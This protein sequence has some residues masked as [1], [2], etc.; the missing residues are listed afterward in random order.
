MTQNDRHDNGRVMLVEDDASTSLFLSKMLEAESYVVDAFTRAEDALESFQLH[1]PDIVLMD[2]NLEGLDGLEATSRIHQLSQGKVP[3]L[4]I[5]GQSDAESIERGFA[6]GAVDFVPKPV[7]WTL[8]KHRINLTLQRIR[9]EK[10]KQLL[11]ARFHAVF[12]HSPMGILLMNLDGSIVDANRMACEICKI[13]RQHFI[14]MRCGDIIHEVSHDHVL[15]GIDNLIEGYETRF[16]E[17]VFMVVGDGREFFANISIS[18]TYDETHK[19]NH[20]VM[21]FDDITQKKHDESRLRLAARVFENASEGIMVTDS[22]GCILDVNE[23]FTRLTEYSRDEVVGNN[24][25]LLQSGHQDQD[26]YEAMWL[27]LESSGTWTGE[28]W[29]RRKSGEVYPELL[30]INAVTDKDGKVVNYVGVFS[31]IS[32][33]KESEERLKYLAYHDPL[34]SLGNRV[35]FRDRVTHALESARR[36]ENKIALLYIDLDHFKTINDNLGH[37]VGDQL[38]EYV[39]YRIKGCVRESDTVA[40]LGGDE[41]SILLERL[42]V[43][44]DVMRVAE[45]VLKKLSEPFRIGQHTVKI[46]GSIGIS[47]FPRDSGDMDELIKLADEAMYE[48]KSGGK[49]RIVFYQQDE[50]K[51]I[52]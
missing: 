4:I 46:G 12:E 14:N 22:R 38:L 35:L 13:P 24:P 42:E 44:E 9:S 33:F 45:C 49:N 15:T 5:T 30:S 34:T 8:L 11:G 36:A 1:T 23:A 43:R 37:D 41:F 48:A 51:L 25:S 3:V 18:V 6:A 28:I 19:P 40:R 21:T 47:C 31:D 32:G 50:S 17:E 52:Q 7:H 20:L 10:Q 29:N 16:A 26:F 39:A 27:E 2:L